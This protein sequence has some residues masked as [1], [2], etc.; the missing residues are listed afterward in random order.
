[1]LK[2]RK[3]FGVVLNTSNNHN[4]DISTLED[5]L[6]VLH[7]K[8][9][10]FMSG[11]RTII[12]NNSL[13]RIR[14]IVLNLKDSLFSNSPFLE[15]TFPQISIYQNPFDPCV[16]NIETPRFNNREKLNSEEYIFLGCVDVYDLYCFTGTEC[17]IFVHDESLNVSEIIKQKHSDDYC[18]EIGHKIYNGHRINA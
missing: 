10:G 3:D 5:F 17:I 11:P 13:G 16:I 9:D 4:E 7:K 6:S 8:L 18:R 15:S 14:D 2:N 12:D 1:L